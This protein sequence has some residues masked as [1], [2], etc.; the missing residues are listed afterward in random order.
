MA[1]LSYTYS[2]VSSSFATM[3]APPTSSAATARSSTAFVV[4]AIGRSANAIDLFVPPAPAVHASADLKAR[5]FDFLA[6]LLQSHSALYSSA[7]LIA[8]FNHIPSSS[9]N[10]ALESSSICSGISSAFFH[11]DNLVGLGFRNHL[12]A[13]NATAI[14][15]DIS[16][17]PAD[18]AYF[19]FRSTVDPS[20]LDPRISTIPALSLEFW[21]ALPQSSIRPTPPTGPFDSPPN[22]QLA[23]DTPTKIRGSPPSPFR[24]AIDLQLL[25]ADELKRQIGRSKGTDATQDYSANCYHLLSSHQ[26]KRLP[27]R[28]PSKPSADS[29]PPRMAPALAYSDSAATAYRGAPDFL[30]IQSASATAL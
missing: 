18:I 9:Y 26:L 7:E 12:G 16:T 17:R 8:A 10:A 4:L 3:S 30:Y 2:P 6:D 22:R 5:S 24:T 1:S 13:P 11:V 14:T 20:A 15:T 27:R 28:S 23:F 21:L 29:A 25:T 19:A